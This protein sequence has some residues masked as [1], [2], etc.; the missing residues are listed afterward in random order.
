MLENP[1]YITE[2]QY[3]E[4]RDAWLYLIESAD[5]EALQE[6]FRAPGFDRLTFL[7]FSLDQIA[8]LVTT[9]DVRSIKAR[10]LLRPESAAPPRFSLTLFAS[11]GGPDTADKCL[12]KYYFPTPAA[13]PTAPPIEPLSEPDTRIPRAEA[14]RWLTDWLTT[15]LTTE[16]FN[17]D[18]GPLRGANFEVSTFQNPLAAAWPY[19]DKGLFLN[20]GLIHDPEPTSA[21]VV[22]IA[23][24]SSRTQGTTEGLPDDDGYYDNGV[25]CPPN[26]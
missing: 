18:I 16:T 22:Y 10:F 1:D 8:A 17:T 14:V 2:K 19:A 24:F 23:P 20:L 12:S 26:H 4:Y 3:R 21:L 25:L 11:D 5:K 15:N 6:A 13:S 9:P 7:T